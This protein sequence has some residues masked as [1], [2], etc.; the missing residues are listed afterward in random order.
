MSWS[1][2]GYVP[3]IRVLCISER[4]S[5]R[6]ALM[7]MLFYASNVHSPIEIED[8]AL[9]HLHVVIGAK[10]RLQQGFFF[11]WVDGVESGGGRSTIWLHHA[12]QL[13]FVFMD[14]R[15]HELNRE[16]LAKLAVSANS[17]AG[18]EFIRESEPAATAVK[19]QRSRQP[20][21]GARRL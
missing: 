3:P 9:A 16:W 14:Q 6:V 10:L 15:R 1:N 8:R 13:R 19:R 21:A 4:R 5:G 18:L 20:S 11:S 12:I 17:Q 2:C 7:G